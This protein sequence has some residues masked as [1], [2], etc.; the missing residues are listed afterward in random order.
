MKIT[1]TC[2]VCLTLGG[3]MIKI[4]LHYFGNYSSHNMMTMK[5][6]MI[7]VNILATLGGWWWWWL[8][9]MSGLLCAVGSCH[10]VVLSWTGLSSSWSWLVN[11]PQ[12]ALCP[13]SEVE[14]QLMQKWIIFWLKVC[15][16]TCISRLQLAFEEMCKPHASEYSEMHTNEKKNRDT[17]QWCISKSPFYHQVHQTIQWHE[18]L[19]TNKARFPFTILTHLPWS[20]A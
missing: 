15:C 13:H 11:T 5:M 19:L 6:V 1:S 8:L 7:M 2:I 9:Y 16:T 14:Y 10:L 18:I 4:Q 12:M 17:K 3:K 20:L